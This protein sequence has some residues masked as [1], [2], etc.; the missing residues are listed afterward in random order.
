M[1][2]S[3][4]EYLR[5]LLEDAR[6]VELRH[7]HGGRWESHACNTVDALETA[8]AERRNAGNLYT[9][10]NRSGDVTESRA[11]RNDDIEVI[12]RIPFDFDPVRP[13]GTPATDAEI[14]AA[15]QARV[16]LVQLLSGY[17]WPM[18]ALGMSGN[19]AHALY[20]TCVK[21]SPAWRSGA[22]VLYAGLRDQLRSPL[23]DLG[24]VFD[25]A[26][27]NPG[28]IWRLYGSM[29]RKGEA[30][31]ERPHR[32][33][34]IALPAGPWQ[35][36]RA[37]ILKRTIDA[38]RPAVV[39]ERRRIA[40]R[41][42][43]INGRG[44]FTTLDVVSWFQAHGAYRRPLED[45]KHAVACPWI[46]EHSTTSPNGTDTVVWEAGTNGWPTFFCAHGHCEDRGLRDVL[47]LWGD[48]DQFC[49]R[50]WRHG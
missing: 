31:Q 10:L 34:E 19:G 44:D 2:S 30:T 1:S 22:A 42:G 37:A 24:V 9:S 36:V 49:A 27:R 29:N 46:G 25:V 21:A 35:P 32:R 12:V 15:Q 45:G 11:L 43:P 3:A 13:T 6:V 50:E 16:L 23:A 18:P 26:V 7:E 38:L 39:H 33:A 47:R 14:E 8:I 28:R 20:R 17:G 41:A 40:A 48:A 5:R 4:R